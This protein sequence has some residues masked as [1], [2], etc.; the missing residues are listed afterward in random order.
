MA[1][2]YAQASA[3]INRVSGGTTSNVWYSLPSQGA[4]S[5]MDTS[6]LTAGTNDILLACNYN[7]T[8]NQD[9]N[10]GE[11]GQLSTGNGTYNGGNYQVG[12]GDRT[13]TAIIKSGTSTCLTTTASGGLL[14]INGSVSGSITSIS[15]YGIDSS[16]TNTKHIQI[17]GYVYGGTGG[18][19][20]TQRSHG[21][22]IGDGST[23]TIGTSGTRYGVQSFYRSGL[24]PFYV[25]AGIIT[26][27]S[28]IT[29]WGTVNGGGNAS[30]SIALDIGAGNCILTVNGNITT[31]DYRY[32]NSGVGINVT[33]TAGSGCIITINGNISSTGGSGVAIAKTLNN[34]ITVNGNIT[35]T[36]GHGVQ[37]SV[38]NSITV[39][40]T[41]TNTSTNNAT[42][43][44]VYTSGPIVYLT[45]NGGNIIN[46]AKNAATVVG[47][48]YNPQ[49]YNYIRFYT[50][51]G[52]TLDYPQ[53]LSADNIKLGI[54][55]GLITGTLSG[56]GS[57]VDAGL[58]N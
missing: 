54:V 58:I 17:N 28:A 15:A 21:V 23:I 33:T 5:W 40:G 1:T 24:G 8:V 10:L 43:Y 16:L 55:S 48:I 38:L 3:D 52:G 47:V 22:N 12:A 46:G 19:F 25:G 31:G 20:A 53:Q 34:A 36:I 56:G 7:I 29:I 27:G 41:L 9:I 44:C 50:D 51:G 35:T 42:Y 18:S 49:P 11:T 26:A 32:N 45:L 6:V 13:I 2:W 30:S 4:G 14:T 39:N 57:L 37:F